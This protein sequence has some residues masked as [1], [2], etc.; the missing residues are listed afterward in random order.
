VN[1]TGAVWLG[2]TIGC[3][4]C[5]DHKFD[6]LSA[7][8]Y[9]SLFAFFNS[10]DE[11]TL[12]LATPEQVA[13]RKD[14]Q[15][16]ITALEKK[17]K[18]IDGTTAQVVEKW[19][20]GLRAEARK[21]LP[22]EVQVI[23][24]IAPN[25]RTPEQ[26]QTVIDAWRNQ[27]QVRHVVA[28]LGQPF[29]AAAQVSVLSQRRNLAREIATL[30]KQV[31]ETVS[32]LVVKE[33]PTPRPTNIMLGGDFTRKGAAVQPRTPAVLP[34]LEVKGNPTRLDLARWIVDPRNPLTARVLVNRM[35]ERYFGLGLVE[36]ENDFGTQGTPPSHPELL[37]WLASEVVARGW[38]LKAM[39]RLIVTSATYRQSSKARP[40]LATLDPRN[41][42]LARQMR[43][44]LDSEV[45]RD[46]AL[47]ASGLFNPTVGG[48]SVFP[49]QPDGVYKFTQVPKQWKTS[50]GPDRYR[51]GLYT[52]VWRSAPHPGLTVFDAPDGVVT[53][54]RRNRSNTPLQAL[55]LLNDQASLEF[56]QGLAARVLREGGSDDEGRIRQAFRICL[57][58]EPAARE[59]QIVQRL[60]DGQR[61]SFAAKPA[62]AKLVVPSVLP[63]NTDVQELAAWTMAARALLNLD[64]FITRE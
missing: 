14:L 39:H 53:C 56:A 19:E 24:A 12:E 32:T 62:D 16:R 23:L 43:L 36:T 2:V 47:T 31:P 29:V 9:Y 49:P 40:D 57:A 44:R 3:C 21:A 17:L 33:R 13:K 11:P 52:W 8:D 45:V 7:R 60:L 15:K 55:T 48:P 61:A 4:Q 34:S 18:Q 30:T 37:D 20:E 25:G 26:Q 10:V 1:T 38:S 64:E 50:T 59:K 42:L 35:W 51:R 5:H 58:R 41:R 6:P 46:V 63:K 22:P 54:T 28:G 27:D